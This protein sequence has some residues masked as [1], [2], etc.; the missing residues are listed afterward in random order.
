MKTKILILIAILSAQLS[1]AQTPISVTASTLTY[2]QDFNTLADTGFANTALPTGWSLIEGGTSAGVNQAYRASDAPTNA[3]DTYSLGTTSERS[4]GAIGSNSLSSKFGVAFTNNSGVA[5]TSF[6]VTFK[7]EQWRSG[8]DT[9]TAQDT[10]NFQYSLTASGISDTLAS[11]VWNSSPALMFNSPNPTAI[12]GALDGN[13]AVNQGN[14]TGT[15]T[16]NIPIGATIYIRWADINMPG[17]DDCLAIDDL[18]IT[19]V[20]GTIPVGIKPNVV[21]TTPLNAA[22]NVSAALT[23]FTI[24][25]DQNIATGT[26][27]VTVKNITDATQVSI[28]ASNCSVSGMTATVPGVSLLAGKNY[29]VWFDSACFNNNGAKSFG[30]YTDQDWN[31]FTE[32]GSFI[33]NLNSEKLNF[34][35]LDNK[36]IEINATENEEINIELISTTGAILAANKYK[37]QQGTNTIKL[38]NY[39]FSNGLYLIKL[40][41][42]NKIGTQKIILN[43]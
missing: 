41:S 24:T 31:F 19:F 20:N 12:S 8:A 28:P 16:V 25:F 21:S 40:T 5:I 1:F 3:G 37:V 2:T 42:Q 35:I 43:K 26:G 11:T 18:S 13:M 34:A 15:V 29:A 17:N 39:N 4:I 7:G 10:L 36:I 33:K 27:N 32:T 9:A 14:V 22:T 38:P 6:D 23:S 30:I